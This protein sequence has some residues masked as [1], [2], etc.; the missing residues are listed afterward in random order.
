M[1]LTDTAIRN[2]KLKE[3]KQTKIF[4]GGGLYLLLRTN[5][6]R[7]WQM[8]YRFAGKPKTL[9]F[10][11][12]PDVTLAVARSKREDAKAKLRNNEDPSVAKSLAKIE[13][14][15]AARNTFGEVVKDYLNKI[16]SEGVVERTLT[17]NRWLLEDL[18]GPALAK[19]PIS[20]IRAAEILSVLMQVHRSG[21]HETAHRLRGIIG[22]VFRY[23]IATLRTETDPTYALRGALPIHEADNRPALTDEKKFG[24]LLVA[25]DGYDGWPTLTAALKL[26]ALCFNR[27][28]NTRTLEWSEI[29]LKERKWSISGEKMK[30]R[31]PHDTYLSDQAM[32][33]LEDIRKFSGEGRLVFPSIRNK[34]RPLSE[35]AMNAAL[36]RM[37]VDTKTEHCAHGFRSSASTILN[38][39][40]VNRD[41]IETQLA[42]LDE[43]EVRRVY[44]RALY[45]NER[46]VMMQQWADLCDKMKVL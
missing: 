4:D 2:A 35:N 8:S 1:P 23:A 14:Q 22:S 38:S 19:R 46:V 42:H 7:L 30:M 9:S 11:T 12:Y 21:R 3:G 31:L 34:E 39:H 20:D 15:V 40:G 18:A 33:V 5:G 17:K 44:N 13:A 32:A 24:R 27:P 45:W 6:S 29:D 43:D 10:G 25:I 41:W 36:Q 26:Q 16:Q 28:V 37:G